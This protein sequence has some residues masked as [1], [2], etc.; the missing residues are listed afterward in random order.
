MLGFYNKRINH[1]SQVV[2][3][4]N[5]QD[6]AYR[7]EHTHIAGKQICGLRN[8]IVHDYEGANPRLV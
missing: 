8:R 2:E 4:A 5:K 1:I 6:E 3:L 7:Q